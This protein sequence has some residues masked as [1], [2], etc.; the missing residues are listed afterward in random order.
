MT[1][2]KRRLAVLV[3]TV[4]MLVPVLLTGPINAAQAAESNP[5]QTLVCLVRAIPILPPPGCDRKDP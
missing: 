5:L 3:G 2:L 1:R 4:A